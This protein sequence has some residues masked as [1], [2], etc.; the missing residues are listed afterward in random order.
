MWEFLFLTGPIWARTVFC[1]DM[2]NIIFMN[3][4]KKHL[5]DIY[6]IFVERQRKE[7]FFSILQDSETFQNLWDYMGISQ[8]LNLEFFGSVPPS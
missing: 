5:P 8:A 6:M 7:P 1:I 4:V 2:R 3:V